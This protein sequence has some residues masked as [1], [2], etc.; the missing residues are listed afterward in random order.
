MTF[1]HKITVAENFFFH[2]MQNNFAKGKVIYK[3]K[4]DKL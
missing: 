1:I 2:Q 4:N 3:Y